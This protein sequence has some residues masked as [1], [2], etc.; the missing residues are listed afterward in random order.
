MNA[1]VNML[2]CKY[3]SFTS[4]TPRGIGW[5]QKFCV[6]RH[7]SGRTKKRQRRFSPAMLY[8]DGQEEISEM[9]LGPNYQDS[10]LD[11]AVFDEVPEDNE[12]QLHGGTSFDLSFEF[13]K[14]CVSSCGNV[15]M[16]D[17]DVQMF[18]DMFQHAVKHN[19]TLDSL[20]YSTLNEYKAYVKKCLDESDDGWRKIDITVPAGTYPGQ[21]SDYTQ[22]FHYRDPVDWLCMAWG[23]ASP[24]CFTLDADCA[25]N[26]QG[27]RI[28]NEP[29]Q[30]DTWINMQN[31]LR[32]H[33]NAN[34]VIA[35]L[36]LY[37]DKTLIN[38][39]GL[40]AHPI[41]AALLNIHHSKRIR[42]LQNVGYFP[43]LSKPAQM[44]AA[45]WRLVKL[46]YM[47]MAIDALLAPLKSLSYDGIVLTSPIDGETVTVY[48]RLLSYVM[49]D[50]EVK[51]LT[52]VKGQG[53][54]HPCEAC[55]VHKDSLLNIQQSWPVRTETHQALIWM[56][57]D[58]AMHGQ[59]E[60]EQLG[61]FLR[62]KVPSVHPVPS[63]LWGF[64][65]QQ[66]GHGNSM[67][68]MAY[69]AMHNEELGL[70]LYGID[71]MRE[72]L[73][74]EKHL[75]SVRAQRLLTEMNR[76]MY[77]LPRAGVS[78]LL[79]HCRTCMYLILLMPCRGLSATTLQR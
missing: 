2:T 30:C 29:H 1:G 59:P 64:A 3:C 36:Q 54:P 71:N 66:D 27:E 49:D 52:G 67:L 25:Y 23:S 17:K 62:E 75:S 31:E 14:A 37:S 63:G 77:L 40:S 56:A 65:G 47:S 22:P 46:R 4:A 7:K 70:F 38:R 69:E 78:L 20:E 21:D 55:W 50:P 41:R 44:S 33:V 68:A 48:P 24:D 79:Q 5:H 61:T 12:E 43:S 74:K 10:E 26:E 76:R 32:A 34:G 28:Y 19:A 15:G 18:L 39:K 45:V 35:A 8:N 6:Y 72:Y 11:D 9:G 58:A 57:H 51:D 13:M 60:P 16:S 42:D 53:A 73:T